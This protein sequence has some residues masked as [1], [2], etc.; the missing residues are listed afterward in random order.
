MRLH[1]H[2]KPVV[3]PD[4]ASRLATLYLMDVL[5]SPAQEHFDRIARITQHLFSVPMCV[6]SFVDADRDWFKSNI[7]F[8]ESELPR[9]IS[10]ASHTILGSD[11]LVIPDT[12]AD[13]RFFDNPLV[14]SQPAIRF[15]AGCPI[16]AWNGLNIGAISIMDFTARN[17]SLEDRIALRDLA[18]TIEHEIGSNEMRLVDDL[19]GL[20]SHRG[21]SLISNH[22]V[23][24]AS[25]NGETLSM[26]FLDIKG[27]DELNQKFGRP[28]GDSALI[29][30]ASVLRETLR[31][32]DIPARMRGDDFA[33]LLPDTGRSE[34]T[35][36]ISRIQRELEERQQEQ[37]LP[38]G[39]VLRYAQAT[40]DPSDED[41]SLEHLI[42]LA[43][44]A[45]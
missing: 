8:G 27:L 7:G 5:D 43:D 40:L 29:M 14:R 25:R 12:K 32:A 45:I 31:S 23:P 4:E 33:I 26:L 37:T 22:I 42:A 6:I 11:I 24:R 10:F 30:V 15:Y 38:E 39:I 34:A 28:F 19:T 41:F 13:V 36:V 3:P 2:L 16:R 20:L 21:L 18:V 17:L 35:V 1:T 9:A 44:I